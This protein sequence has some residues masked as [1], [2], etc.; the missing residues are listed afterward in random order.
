LQDR[1][2]RKRAS[3]I[4]ASACGDDTTENLAHSGSQVFNKRIAHK[5]RVAVLCFHQGKNAGQFLILSEN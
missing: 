1:P 2:G 4:Q 5:R 3:E